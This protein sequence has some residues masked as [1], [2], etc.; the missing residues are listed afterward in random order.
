MRRIVI[1]ALAASALALGALGAY[2]QGG[3]P[4]AGP[5]ERPAAAEQGH[6]A[7]APWMHDRDDGPRGRGM[8][9]DE[10]RHGM[11]RGMHGGKHGGMHGGMHRG[12]PGHSPMMM[13]MMFAV[14]DADGDGEVSLEEMQEIQA[15]I[16]RAMDAD[17]SG[18]LTPEEIRGFMKPERGMGRGMGPG[19]HGGMGGGMNG[20]MGGA[21]APE[22]PPASE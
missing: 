1:P 19:T 16:F 17:D 15:R 22:T 18:G 10:G 12:G 21:T 13:K 8:G 11:H 6:G 7:K 20:G 9:P 4:A 5:A 3:S 14:A 2:A